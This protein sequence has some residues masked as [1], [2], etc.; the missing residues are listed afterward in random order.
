MHGELSHRR[1]QETGRAGLIDRAV[2]SQDE[3][4]IK[5]TEARPRE[6]AL[7]PRPV[8]LRAA[9]DAVERPGR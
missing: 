8:Y 7:N 6:Y 9:R 4:A 2:A 5:L 1:A 3:H